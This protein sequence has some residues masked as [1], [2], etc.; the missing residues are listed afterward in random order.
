ML[1]HLSTNLGVRSVIL[2]KLRIMAD[3][4]ASGPNSKPPNKVNIWVLIMVPTPQ[5]LVKVDHLLMVVL[6]QRVEDPEILAPTTML[7]ALTPTI[8][9]PIRTTLS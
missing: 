3:L 1:V 7:V 4:P 8:F 5:V 6:L 2:K 9:L